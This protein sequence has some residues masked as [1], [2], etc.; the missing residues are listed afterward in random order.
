MAS[1]S[2]QDEQLMV[3][4]RR[5][6]ACG[7][8]EASEVELQSPLMRAEPRDLGRRGSNNREESLRKTAE[9]KKSLDFEIGAKHPTFAATDDNALA[10]TLYPWEWTPQCCFSQCKHPW[11][12][13][14][15][16]LQGVNIFKH[17]SWHKACSYLSFKLVAWTSMATPDYE[18]ICLHGPKSMT[19]WRK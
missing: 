5:A 13:P 12:P 16:L 17:Q 14:L 8:P 1:D 7:A 4:E 10:G 19:D 9:A 3:S 11:W 15:N 6:Q 2:R 18:V